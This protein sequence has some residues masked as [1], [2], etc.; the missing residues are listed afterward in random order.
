MFGYEGMARNLFVMKCNKSN[1]RQP[2]V[3]V[4]IIPPFDL[5]DQLRTS[6]TATLRNTTLEVF[7]GKALGT[8]SKRDPLF[9]ASGE[10]DKISA[11]HDFSSEQDLL[12]FLKLFEFDQLLINWRGARMQY[13]LFNKNEVTTRE[14]K[15]QF[16]VDMIKSGYYELSYQ[17]LYLSCVKFFSNQVSMDALVKQF[18]PAPATQD[19]AVSSAG[20]IH[21]PD[22]RVALVI[23][24]SSYKNVPHL[25]NPDNDARLISEALKLDGFEVTLAENVDRNG[26]I[27]A[28]RAFAAQADQSDWAVVYFAGH[29]IE[30]AGTNYLIPTDARLLTDRDI[31]FEAVSLNQVMKMIAGARLLR[32]VILDACRDNPF[33]PIMKRT[34]GEARD[35]ARGLA[36]IEPSSG[37]LVLYSS[38]EGTIAMD[39]DGSNSPF[40]IALARHLSDPGVEVDKMFRLVRDDVLDATGNKQEPFLYGSLP[41]RQ[42]FQFRLQ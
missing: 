7:D 16:I 20:A 42:S 14:F 41:G 12:N 18:T 17:D 9:S 8:S 22:R 36:R 34:E 28:M 11:F 3:T 25:T 13:M 15:E 4:E 32:V 39:G 19:T 40:A 23:G 24:N 33:A 30:V 2:R 21:P 29:G 6:A 5:A 27:N 10:Y 1:P 38:K 35:V 37:T 26:L 31:D